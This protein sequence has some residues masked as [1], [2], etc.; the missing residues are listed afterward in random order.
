MSL[1][2]IPTIA[3]EKVDFLPPD[4]VT[5][6]GSI[7]TLKSL[8]L[9]PMLR[10]KDGAI[11]PGLFDHWALDSSGCLWTLQIR[12]GKTFHDGSPV[13]A[14]Q[15]AAFISR[16]MDSRDMFGMPWSYAR[17]LAGARMAADGLV[18]TIE[19]PKPFPDLPEILS[20]F[21]LPRMDGAGRPVIGT[22]PWEVETF[23]AGQEV[24]LRRRA[25]G[26]RRRFVALPRAED[27]LAALHSGQV[28]A[29]THMERLDSVR[30]G[31]DGFGWQEQASTMSV[32][33]YMNGFE[34][35]FSDPR[36][37]L[38][39]NLAIDRTRLIA[40]VMG[41]LALPSDTIVSPWHFGHPEAGL[42]PMGHAPDEARRLL[43]ASQAPREVVLRSPTY[44]PERAPEIARFLAEAWNAVGFETRVEIAEDRPQYAR[45]IG[46][47]K[48]GDVA[49]FDSSPHSTFRVLDDKIS[50]SSRAVWWQG[51]EDQQVDAGF[52]AAR[53]ITDNDARARAYGTI[54]RRLQT[55]PPWVYLFHPV[56]CLAHAPALQGLSLDHKGI[57]RIA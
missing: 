10:W 40:E 54:L 28:Q 27:R 32:M 22:G 37:R 30:R 26:C 47:K 38:A 24:L 31:L 9:D 44:M 48:M 8:V 25:D 12:P 55:A 45:D 18:L 51:V 23:T 50:A 4:R 1:P 41:G 56:L 15:A 17:Y 20:E 49:I 29:A 43:A 21:Y 35:S 53:H 3:L 52:D 6:D 11:Q 16:I 36:A 33:A 34:G 14:E 42:T 7:L 39:A 19:T 57:L 5:D 2:E 13:L 46:E